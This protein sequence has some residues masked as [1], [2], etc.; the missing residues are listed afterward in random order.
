M[1]LQLEA[2]DRASAATSATSQV[3]RS[4]PPPCPA[5][6]PCEEAALPAT[7]A[8][9]R[10]AIRASGRFDRA[11]IL[12]V[13]LARARVERDAFNAMGLPQPWA[14]LFSHELRLT[15]QVAKAAMDG[16]IAERV[17]AR[18]EPAERAART[19]DLRADMLTSAIP[20]RAADGDALRMTA[21]EMRAGNDTGASK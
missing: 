12:R 5:P 13:A 16:L 1:A 11:L 20:P 4:D 14:N 15:W 2:R 21:A 18:L 10:S 8:D 6:A 17:R 19:L 3:R 9:L 7:W